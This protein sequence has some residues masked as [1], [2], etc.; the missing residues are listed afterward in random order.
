MWWMLTSFY[1]TNLCGHD[2]IRHSQLANPKR[3]MNSHLAGNIVCVRLELFSYSSTVWKDFYGRKFITDVERKLKYV[4][5][6]ASWTFFSL[7]LLYWSGYHRVSR[8]KIIGCHF[9]L[10]VMSTG[11]VIK[12][13]TDWAVLCSSHTHTQTKNGNEIEKRA[14]IKEM[15]EI[16]LTSRFKSRVRVLFFREFLFSFFFK[17]ISDPEMNSLEAVPH[18]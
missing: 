11:R 5:S 16:K 12:K 14:K 15:S 8:G 2:K 7:S 4:D 6:M 3:L 17:I 1:V 18:T 10:N 9:V 13:T